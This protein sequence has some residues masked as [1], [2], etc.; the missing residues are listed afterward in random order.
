MI[1]KLYEKYKMRNIPN[2]F[3]IDEIDTILK[4]EYRATEI[5]K[6]KIGSIYLDTNIEFKEIVKCYKIEEKA[7][8]MELFSDAEK[9]NFAEMIQLNQSEQNTDFN[10]QDLFNKEIQE[11]KL[12]VIFLASADGTYINYFNLLG[13]SEMMYNKLTVLMGLEKEECNIE[14]PLFQEYLQALAA[15]GYLEE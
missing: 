12:I 1:N 6:N 5:K 8:L 11:G 4:S 15:I 2:K 10:E 3:S 14:N 7:V 9:K 13:H